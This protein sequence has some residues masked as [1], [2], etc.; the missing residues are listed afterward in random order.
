[1]ALHRCSF[2]QLFGQNR[3]IAFSNPTKR[4]K[5]AR[6]SVLEM[7]APSRVMDFSDILHFESDHMVKQLLTTTA[8]EGQFNPLMVLNAA[9]LNVVTT[10]VFAQR[11]DSVDDP[12]FK[13]SYFYWV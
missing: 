13:V 11:V 6:T 7:L 12:L 3:G 10:I 1:M 5:K 9:S 4:W 2:T 8:K